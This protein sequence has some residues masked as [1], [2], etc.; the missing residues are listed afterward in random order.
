VLQEAQAHANA[1]VLNELDVNL[2]E[3]LL[4]P[5]DMEDTLNAEFGSLSLNAISGTENGEVGNLEPQ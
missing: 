4:Q 2:T 1:L 5:L 3:E